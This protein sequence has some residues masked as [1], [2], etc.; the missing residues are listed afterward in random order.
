[1]SPDYNIVI[2][3]AHVNKMHFFEHIPRLQLHDSGFAFSCCVHLVKVIAVGAWF[4]TD[5]LV[6]LAITSPPPQGLHVQSS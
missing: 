4:L 1:M 2:K 3:L 6:I 5:N